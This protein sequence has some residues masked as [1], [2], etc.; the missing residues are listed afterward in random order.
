VRRSPWF[1]STRAALWG[2]VPAAVLFALYDGAPAPRSPALVAEPVAPVTRVVVDAATVAAVD[3]APV[4]AVPFDAGVAFERP[5]QAI[6]L[7]TW[8]PVRVEARREAQ[9]L[10]YLRA[11]ATVDVL[12]G[13]VGRDGCVVHRDHPEGGWYHVRGGGFV[14]VGGNFAMPAPFRGYRAPTQPDLGAA[15]PYPYAINYGR[16]VMY[17]RLPTMGDLHTFE[18]WRFNRGGAGDGGDGGGAEL[19][20]GNDLDAGAPVQSPAGTAADPGDT[21]ENRAARRVVEVR[22]AGGPPRLGDLAGERGGPVVRRLLSGM[23]VALDRTVRDGDTDEIYW[24]TQSGG[25]IRNGRLSAVRNWSRFAGQVMDDAHHL[26]MAWMVSEQG[27]EYTPFANGAGASSHRRVAR[28]TFFQLADAPP[29]RAGAQTFWR[30][31]DGHAVNQRN[32]RRAVLRA[33]PE[34]VGPTETW[35]DVDLDEQVLVAYEGARPVFATLI[36]SGRGDRHSGVRNYESPSGSFRIQ[37]RHITTTMDGDTAGDGPYSIEDVPWVMYFHGSYALHGA[38]WHTYFGW[39][40]SHGCINLSPPDARWVFLWATPDL[41]AGWHGVYAGDTQPGAR[42]ELRHSRAN[43]PEEDRPASA[44]HAM[45]VVP[46][47]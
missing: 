15:M 16:S 26:P 33:P 8:T 35:I 14:C 43:A 22:D 31:A 28:Q 21:V 42:V 47:Q 6:A 45:P 20:A 32:V 44:A 39:R 37:S 34:G 7:A 1:H 24:R 12:D 19:V 18:A 46:A 5:A 17:R 9:A 29:I 11:G 13:P 23:Y 2:A 38:F 27:W 3:A 4:A 36:S 30:T 10:G 40:M 41:P 25:F